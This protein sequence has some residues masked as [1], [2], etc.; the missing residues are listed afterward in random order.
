[1]YSNPPLSAVPLFTLL[2][3]HGQSSPEILNGKLQKK[4]NGKFVSFKLQPF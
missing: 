2:L 4:L 3:T 1:M